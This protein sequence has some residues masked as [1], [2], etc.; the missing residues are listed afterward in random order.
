MHEP[1]RNP[2]TF[3]ATARTHTSRHTHARTHTCEEPKWPSIPPLTRQ[4]CVREG[5]MGVGGGQQ[6]KLV[7]FSALLTFESLPCGSFVVF[8]TLPG[9]H[10]RRRRRTRSALAVQQPTRVFFFFFFIF[11]QT[12]TGRRE[13]VCSCR[14]AQRSRRRGGCT[15]H[16]LGNDFRL[17]VSKLRLS[18]HSYSTSITFAFFRLEMINKSSYSL[19]IYIF[20][21]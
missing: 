21:V 10:Y 11:C 2:T 5:R 18:F 8:L 9:S 7:T 6:H 4:W 16:T 19:K 14:A 15:A 1:S 17:R 13:S 3:L 12:L 20:M